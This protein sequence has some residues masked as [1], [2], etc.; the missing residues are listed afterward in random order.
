[1]SEVK[2]HIINM[3]VRA[4]MHIIALVLMTMY[5]HTMVQINFSYG[6]AA[7]DLHIY[8]RKYMHADI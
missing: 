4:R 1:M 8:L 2:V 7:L 6:K 5:V 3:L